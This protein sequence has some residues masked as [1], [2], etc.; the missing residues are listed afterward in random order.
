MFSIHVSYLIIKKIIQM[1][2]NVSEG[3]GKKDTRER[4]QTKFAT[5]QGLISTLFT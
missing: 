4:K 5:T 1:Y 2:C 3:Q